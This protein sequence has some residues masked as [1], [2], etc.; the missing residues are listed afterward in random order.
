[1]SFLSRGKQPRRGIADNLGMSLPRAIVPGRRYMITRRCSERRFF[2]RPDKET[3]NAF[4]YCLALAARKT[5]VSIVCAGTMS[6]RYHAILV[7]SQ[8]KLPQFLEH[9]HKFYA[10]H[11][12]ALRGRWEAFWA[13]EQTSVVELINHED[14]IKKMVYAITNPVAGHLVEKVHHWPGVESLTAIEHNK[15]L[16]ATKPIRFFD[17]ENDDLPDAIALHFLR[18]PGYENLSQAEYTK[19][20]RDKVA[21][22]E[23]KAAAERRENGIKL[24]GRKGVSSQ[25]WSDCSGTHEPRRKLS[26]RV[27][28]K[29]TWARVEAL[30]RN[31]S[32]IDRYREARAD[33]LAG[34]ETIFPAGT[35]WLHRFACVKCADAGA[36]APPP[37]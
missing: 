24:L 12:N 6:N 33:H 2:M 8:G 31:Q 4:I 15:P 10:K 35:W 30:Q 5:S 11:Q 14:V 19:L 32:F 7:D 27:A 18:A 22:A 3:N 34:R 21:E 23:Q 28:C 1:L 9:F 17:P 16:T 20:L 25:P 37:S 26:P 36:T 13:S 29:N